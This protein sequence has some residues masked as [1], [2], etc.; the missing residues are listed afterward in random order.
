MERTATTQ[1]RLYANHIKRCKKMIQHI[2]D[3][4]DPRFM[5]LIE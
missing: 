4:N 2:Q 3:V 1:V 5:P